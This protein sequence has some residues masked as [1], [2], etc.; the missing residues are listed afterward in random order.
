MNDNKTKTK[1]DTRD[2]S[3]NV[4]QAQY[5]K[6]REREHRDIMEFMHGVYSQ[7]LYGPKS[8]STKS[9]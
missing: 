2:Y 6:A 4:K 7:Y 5:D 3:V 1:N 9:I 8:K